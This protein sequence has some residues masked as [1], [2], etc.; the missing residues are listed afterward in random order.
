MGTEL[1]AVAE[2]LTGSHTAAGTLPW[3]LLGSEDLRVVRR[4]AGETLPP[5]A[6]RRLLRELRNVIRS[7]EIPD[8]EPSAALA[9]PALLRV[10]RRSEAAAPIAARPARLLLELCRDAPDDRAP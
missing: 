4:W 7:A 9:A 1:E 5:P 10:Q 3:R 6:E 8:D 2:F